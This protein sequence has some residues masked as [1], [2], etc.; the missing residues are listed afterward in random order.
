VAGRE[1]RLAQMDKLYGV[2]HAKVN[3]QRMLRLEIIIVIFFA[4]DLMIL[5]WVRR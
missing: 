4:V 1:Q 3:E 2:V 5:L